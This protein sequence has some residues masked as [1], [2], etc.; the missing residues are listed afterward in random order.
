MISGAVQAD[1]AVLVISARKGEFETGFENGGQTREHAILVKSLGIKHL[2]VLINKMDDK[3]VNWSEDRFNECKDKLLPFL[4]KKLGFDPS[5]KD[6]TFIPVSGLTGAGIKDPVPCHLCPWYSGP[7]FIPYIDGISTIDRKVDGPFLLPI[8]G[9]YKDKKG[10][11]TVM[12]KV[13]CGETRK[14]QSLVVMPFKTEV[15]V[16]GL[17]S[18]EKKVVSVGHGDNVKIRLKGIEEN[19]LSPGL[20]LC[21]LTA[22]C[23]TGKVFDAQV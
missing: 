20:V 2:I 19:N 12:G 10:S 23:T 3:T 22:P 6:L 21:H 15:T 17:W 7:P 14:G 4:T 9:K 11:V 8:T 1:L 13:E 18:N 16:E 5:K